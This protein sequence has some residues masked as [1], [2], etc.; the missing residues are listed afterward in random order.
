MTKTWKAPL[1]GL[2]IASSY[3]L[4]SAI[5]QNCSTH[6]ND[7]LIADKYDPSYDPGKDATDDPH[8]KD[9]HDEQHDGGL[10]GGAKMPANGAD[11]PAKGADL[12]ANDPGTYYNY[13]P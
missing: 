3:V 10:P 9:P 12:P 2:L 6:H 11:M 8:G 1:V 7:L 13:K 5:V 4:T